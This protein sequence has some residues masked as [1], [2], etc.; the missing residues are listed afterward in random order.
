MIE[1]KKES[2]QSILKSE[3]ILS[4][5]EYQR[6]FDWG[7]EE[8]NEMIDDLKSFT[9]SDGTNLFLG[10]FIFEDNGS[11]KIFVVD[12]Q[13]RLT[14]INI[15]LVAVREQAKNINEIGFAKEIQNYLSISSE[16]LNTHSTK[17]LVSHT[18]KDVFEYI[19]KYD[20]EKDFPDNIGSKSVKRQKNKLRPL[21]NCIYDEIKGYNK[22]D[23][24]SFTQSLLMSYVIVL[25]VTDQ[26]DVFTIFERTNARG[27]DLN[28]ADLFKNYLFSKKIDEV[29]NFW[30]DITENSGSTLLRML[31][32]YWVSKNG[33][34]VQSKL[35]R[36]IK[37]HISH[38]QEFDS[39]YVVKYIK[40]LR[41]FSEFYKMYNSNENQRQELLDWLK[42]NEL[43]VLYENETYV[44]S[45]LRSLRALK[46]FRVNQP[47]PFIYSMLKA[48]KECSLTKGDKICA[49]FNIVESYHFINNYITGKV[50]NE[51]E[52]FYG[53][54]AK[55]FSIAK[56]FNPTAEKLIIGL[57]NRKASKDEFV[58]SL[59]SELIYD[60][61]KIAA[62]NYFFDRLNNYDFDKKRFLKGGQY[63]SIF[64]PE[65][66]YKNRNYNIEHLY[67]QKFNVDISD[68]DKYKINQ[69]GNLLVISRHTNS[70][71][72]NKSVE[73]KVNLLKTDKKYSHNLRYIDDFIQDFE[74]SGK[75]WDF[76]D[77]ED[78][79]KKLSLMAYES[80]WNF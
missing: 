5:P 46:L 60:R 44:E 73:D 30:E 47:I 41:N 49:I 19:I 42:S 21:F 23:L 48:A 14:T 37:K 62:L 59:E 31:K 24:Q 66:P 65:L 61:K 58:A 43:S 57:K 70:E 12:G 69:L 32:Y 3:K 68:E 55:D 51:V 17:F 45:I 7:K 18:I 22:S 80:I 39:N 77:I 36:E 53:E 9:K 71:F 75:K 56:E 13:Q 79:T 6:S 15:I 26:E 54:I 72:G 40:E 16:V 28:T 1:P 34:I 4:I 64:N 50:A 33:H 38:N 20:W 11:N 2:L 74:N 10:N 29:N 25:N 78:R 27:L 35:Y 63:A 8:L 52:K 67:A 76:K